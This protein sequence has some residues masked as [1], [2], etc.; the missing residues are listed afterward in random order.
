[1][2][3]EAMRNT[4]PVIVSNRGGMPELVNDI[5]YI[6]DPDDPDALFSMLKGFVEGL[7]GLD[8]IAFNRQ[9]EMDSVLD[10]YLHV[11]NALIL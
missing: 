11:Y 5:R 4:C 2:I 6:F 9:F 1:M 7:I 3:V 8:P 10:A